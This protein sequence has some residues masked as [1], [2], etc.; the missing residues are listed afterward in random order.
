[1]LWRHELSAGR[2]D[3]VRHRGTAIDCGTPPDYLRANLHAS[4]GTSVIGAGATVAGDIDR[5]VV[6]PGATVAAGEHLIECVRA[7]TAA[8]P[9]TVAAPLGDAG[10]TTR[11][12]DVST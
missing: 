11:R 9:V 10:G 12:D 2:L 1:V 6:W 5:C 3:L 4:G 7:G 8:E